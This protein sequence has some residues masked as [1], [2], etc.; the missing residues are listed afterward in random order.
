MFSFVVLCNYELLFH[1]RCTVNAPLA[2]N[3]LHVWTNL[4]QF[5]FCACS[6]LTRPGI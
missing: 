2:P 5:V 1:T 4:L 3:P 6:G